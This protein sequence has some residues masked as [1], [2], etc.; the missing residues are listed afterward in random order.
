MKVQQLRAMQGKMIDS[1]IR[2]I[3]SSRQQPCRSGRGERKQ[4]RGGEQTGG[5][6]GWGGGH[7]GARLGG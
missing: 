2:Q 1:P 3:G 4:E 5:D 7:E 6:G